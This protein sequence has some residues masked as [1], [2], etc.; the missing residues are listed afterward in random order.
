MGQTD[1]RFKDRFEALDYMYKEALKIDFDIA[2]IGC[3][4]YGI[5]LASMLKNA[6]KQAFHLGGITQLWFGI[7]GKRWDNIPKSLSTI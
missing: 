5:C 6:G 7:K 3:G 1:E 4:A 2:V